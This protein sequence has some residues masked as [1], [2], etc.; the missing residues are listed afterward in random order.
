MKKVTRQGDV[1]LV[2]TSKVNGV[3]KENKVVAYG[4]ISGHHHT[5]VGDAELIEA[6]GKMYVVTGKGKAYLAHL[7]ESDMQMADH[8]P[9]ELEP[10][11]TYEVVLQNQFNP[12]SKLM[13]R[14]AD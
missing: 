13:E 14:V 9:V 12:Y 7:K 4:E 3:K 11:T 1:A 10:E 2:P 5:L 8:H 6:E